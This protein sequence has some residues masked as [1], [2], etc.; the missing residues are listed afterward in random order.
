MQ[1]QITLKDLAKLYVC[2]KAVSDSKVLP[3]EAALML[4]TLA[5]SLKKSFESHESKQGG[6][7]LEVLEVLKA[8]THLIEEHQKQ[9]FADAKGNPEKRMY[10]FQELVSM[11]DRVTDY[12]RREIALFKETLSL[13]I[14]PVTID[15]EI[16]EY[17]Q[18]YMHR[19]VKE[20]VFDMQLVFPAIVEV[21]F[22]DNVNKQSPYNA[23]IELVGE[24]LIELKSKPPTPAQAL[25]SDLKKLNPKK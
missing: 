25:K 22:Q 4:Q 20:Y 23:F 6:T 19:D 18:N 3:F 10:I 15:L 8:C 24:G 16:V 11:D 9:S 1:L 7:T 2:A 17:V 12:R 13:E 21:D 14:N 5:K